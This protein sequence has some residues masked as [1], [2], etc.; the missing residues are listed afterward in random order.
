MKKIKLLICVIVAASVVSCSSIVGNLTEGLT[1]SLYKQKD[2]ELIEDGAPAFL[3]LIESFIEN[4]PNDRNQLVTGI[5]TF[6]AY[7]S[8]FVDDKERKKIFSDKTK[9]WALDLLRTYPQFDNYEN[10]GDRDAKDAAFKKFLSGLKKGDVKYVFWAANAWI[11][12]IIDNLDSMDAFLELPVAKEIVTRIKEID[13]DFYYGAP[14]LF[15]GVYYSAF[16]ENFGG[17]LKKA[18]EEFDVAL[19]LSGDEFL[20]TKLF[21]ATFYLTAIGDKEGFEKVLNEII[22]MDIEKYPDTRLL[23]IVSKS[24]AEKMIEKVDEMFINLE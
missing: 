18:K 8:A 21:Y 6:S 15:D 3:L 11:M 7:S 12:W 22:D 4:S 24:Q 16:P 10:I 20:T 19:K 23:N 2:I 1:K 9:G 14:H 17:N 13:G 5:Q